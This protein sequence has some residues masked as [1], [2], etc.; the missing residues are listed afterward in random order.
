MASPHLWRKRPDVVIVNLD[1]AEI[2]GLELCRYV[3]THPTLENTTLI[4]VSGL[5]EKNWRDRTSEVGAAGFLSKPVTASR[6][7]EIEALASVPRLD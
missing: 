1:M 4:A 6:V 3:L 2:D 5:D 7:M